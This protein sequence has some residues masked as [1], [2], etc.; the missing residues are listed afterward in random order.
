MKRTKAAPHGDCSAGR[1]LV[2][3]A[4]HATDIISKEEYGRRHRSN[5]STPTTRVSGSDEVPAVPKVRK[6][7]LKMSE[8]KMCVAKRLRNE[9]K[10]YVSRST[11]MVVSGRVIGPNCPDKC[12]EKIGRP[13]IEDVFKTFWDLGS[14]MKQTAYLQSLM[15]PVDVKRRRKS[16]LENPRH[17]AISVVYCIKYGHQSFNI[18]KRGF[19]SVFGIGKRRVEVA[20]CKLTMT[21]T[22]ESDQRG[23]HNPTKKKPDIVVECV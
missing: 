9:G 22:P 21:A 19:C 6:R 10:A 12:M 8:W 20:V 17:R 15:Q 1:V 4:E 7:P 5:T 13:V 3:K 2:R 16:K 11:G 23:A 18:C 14:Y